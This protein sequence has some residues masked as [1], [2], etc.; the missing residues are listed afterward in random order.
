VRIAVFSDIH[1]NMDAFRQVMID[2]DQCDI[3]S[4]YCL[5]DNV[6][7]GPEPEKVLEVFR[8]KVIPS[9]LGNHDLACI[10]RSTLDWFNPLAAESLRKTIKMLSPESIRYLKSLKTHFLHQ[11][12]R[13]VHG[14]PPDSPKT[15]L[16]QVS[17]KK[18]SQYMSEMVEK[19]CFLG[20]T[21]ELRIIEFDED[22]LHFEL[23]KRGVFKLKEGGRYFINVGSVGQ[24]RDGDNR[25]KYV[26][27][28]TEKKELEVR[29][30]PYDIASVVEKIKTAGLPEAHARRLW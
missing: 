11:G 12:S 1:G 19:I 21:H 7:Y 15:Y 25:A 2:I 6:G 24:P 29:F 26:I 17:R 8:K 5:G 23:L 4:V 10:D 22:G 14:F 30:I 13:F 18:I 9:V 3:D 27:W 16:F 28:D 20:H